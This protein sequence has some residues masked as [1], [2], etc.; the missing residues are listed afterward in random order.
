MKNPSNIMVLGDLER[1]S[2]A[3]K[4]GSCGWVRLR[5]DELVERWKVLEQ[6]VQQG[7][8]VALKWAGAA[9]ASSSV[10]AGRKRK[11][12]CQDNAGGKRGGKRS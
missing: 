1:V 5:N 8:W 10:L 7:T 4:D 6:E 3:L 11:R 12:N 9:G 2:K